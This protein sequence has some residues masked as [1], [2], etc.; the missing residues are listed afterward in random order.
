MLNKSDGVRPYL[1]ESLVPGLR[2]AL[3]KNRTN[4]D[5]LAIPQLRIFEIGKVWREGQEQLALGFSVES[6]KGKEQAADF[7]PALEALVGMELKPR[8]SPH[9]DDQTLELLLHGVENRSA[10]AYD[11]LPLSDA[12]RFLP[13]SKYP[14]IVRDVAAWVPAGTNEDDLR[15]IIGKEAGPLCLSARIF[16]RFEKDGKVSLA[17]RLTFQSMERTLEDAEANACMEKVHATLKAK[18]YE[19]R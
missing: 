15:E 10:E 2:E 16:D 14:Y 18:G 19:I 17:Y 9:S 6:V 1:R 8:I 4:K 5:L 11:L 7:I 12:E 3:E 13:F